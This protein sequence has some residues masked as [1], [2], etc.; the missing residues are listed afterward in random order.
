MSVRMAVVWL[1][2]KV[3]KMQ[4]IPFRSRK[5][6]CDFYK[7]KRHVVLSDDIACSLLS[8]LATSELFSIIKSWKS[9]VNFVIRIVNRTF[10]LYEKIRQ[11][12]QFWENKVKILKFC[13]TYLK[14]CIIISSSILSGKTLCSF[15]LIMAEKVKI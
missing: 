3:A 13:C 9:L 12:F 5:F 4:A 7:S 1:R 8:P 6:F 11:T 14:L 15:F 10:T 2:L